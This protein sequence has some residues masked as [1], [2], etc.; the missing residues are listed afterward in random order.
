MKNKT[1]KQV[2]HVKQFR[3]NK[4]VVAEWSSYGSRRHELPRGADFQTIYQVVYNYPHF[5]NKPYIRLQVRSR[6]APSDSMWL[7]RVPL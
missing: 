5:S 4:V 7:Q 3:L 6:G 1:I 2:L